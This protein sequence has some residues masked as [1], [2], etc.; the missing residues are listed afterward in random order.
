MGKWVIKTK[1]DQGFDGLLSQFGTIK[2]GDNY[3]QTKS[4]PSGTTYCYVGDD[5]EDF[6]STRTLKWSDSINVGENIA[7][8]LALID[9][10]I[11]A[12]YVDDDNTIHHNTSSDDGDSW[13]YDEAG[14]GEDGYQMSFS[15][16]M[17]MISVFKLGSTI[18]GHFGSNFGIT[19][20]TRFY[21]LSDFSLVASNGYNCGGGFVE[22]GKYY[23]PTD[24]TGGAGWTK[25][26]SFNGTTI[27]DENDTIDEDYD[28]CSLV[29]TYTTLLRAGSQLFFSGINTS[30][31]YLRFYQKKDDDDWGSLSESV[32]DYCKISFYDDSDAIMED[33]IPKFIWYQNTGGDF[34]IFHIT[35]NGLCFLL[36]D[37]VDY[38]AGLLAH[39][40]GDWLGTYHYVEPDDFDVTSMQ[41]R[42]KDHLS[43]I[44]CRFSISES[45]EIITE[46]QSLI[47]TDRNDSDSIIYM[48][49][50]KDITRTYG[51]QMVVCESPMKDAF[52][53]PV[54]LDSYSSENEYNMILDF[55]DSHPFFYAGT[56]ENPSGSWTISEQKTKDPV[57]WMRELEVMGS[58]YFVIDPE[59]N[60]DYN[61]ADESTGIALTDSNSEVISITEKGNRVTG[62]IVNGGFDTDNNRVSSGK[63]NNPSGIYQQISYIVYLVPSLQTIQACIDR[64]NL[65]FS[66]TGVSFKHYS[67]V[68]YDQIMPQTG[69]TLT[70][71]NSF[72][73]LSSETIIIESFTWDIIQ[74]TCKIDCYSHMWFKSD[75]ENKHVTNVETLTNQVATNTQNKFEELFAIGSS[76]S[77]KIPMIC[78][79]SSPVDT[80]TYNVR[81]E[82]TGLIGFYVT[83]ILP[84]PTTKGSLD[85]YLASL[86]VVLAQADGSNYQSEVKVYGLGGTAGTSYDTL[87]TNSTNYTSAAA[88]NFNFTDIDASDYDS[89]VVTIYGAVTTAS[90]FEILHVLMECYYV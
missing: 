82:N 38:D 4:S 40:V 46:G 78:A 33:V 19:H 50:A 25:V 35:R 52:Q 65:I 21:D 89:I 26:Y 22:D 31:G 56:I 69:E 23:Y 24:S 74:R 7:T 45:V 13:S 67:I 77:Q 44:E 83:Y 58:R 62:I 41:L 76:N 48:G 54:D 80:F 61:E 64:G 18:Y 88:N 90:Y 75:Y 43:Q 66:T 42:K 11:H 47:V 9:G 10:T 59:G 63:M 1:T 20:A 5:P 49:N 28:C 86:D 73:S 30:T 36:D 3:I 57:Q 85:L 12:T 68:M 60:L 37:D 6:I 2:S 14:S 27:T 39:G 55:M 15:G 16:Y 84:I 51:M 17:T 53:V 71:T 79:G 32:E 70:I 34:V 72:H 87:Y 29:P 8:P 81:L